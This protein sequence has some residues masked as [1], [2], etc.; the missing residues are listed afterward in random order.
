LTGFTDSDWGGSEIDGRSTIGGCF[1]LGFAMISWMSRK[2]DL[3]A[4]SSAKVE[5]IDACEVGKEVVWLR[6]LLSNLFGKSLDPTKIIVIIKATSG[7]LKS[8]YSMQ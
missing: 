4:L 5:Y 1:S 2:H 8:L 6:N 7:C 3:V